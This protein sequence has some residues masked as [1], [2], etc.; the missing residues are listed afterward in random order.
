MAIYWDSHWEKQM[1]LSKPMP[2][3]IYLVKQKLMAKYLL[4]EI[5]KGSHL[6]KRTD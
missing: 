4:M 2:M 3:V 1:G 6:V 5:L